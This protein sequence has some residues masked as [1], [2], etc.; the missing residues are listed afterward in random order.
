MHALPCS[1]TPLPFPFPS[2]PQFLQQ[3]HHF[4]ANL[5]LFRLQPSQESKT[6]QDLV[7][8]LSQVGWYPLTPIHNPQWDQTEVSSY[9]GWGGHHQFPVSRTVFA[10]QLAW[11]R[12]ITAGCFGVTL[13]VISH[14]FILLSVIWRDG[15][16]GRAGL[17]ARCTVLRT[18]T[19][20]LHTML[21]VCT[22]RCG[23]LCLQ[24]PRN[25][26]YF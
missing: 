26:V 3:Y 2:L 18:C 19:R 20:I 25:I 5:E 16:S 24:Q 4:Q 1:C 15:C 22:W 12:F 17:H 13:P 23:N 8:F 9:L 11:L 14:L 21:I 10:A 6:I 7:M